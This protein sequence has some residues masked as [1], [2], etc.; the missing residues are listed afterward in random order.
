MNWDT[1]T[2]KDVSLPFKRK[3]YTRRVLTLHGNEMWPVKKENKLTLR[4]A[5]MRMIKWMCGINNRS[6]VAS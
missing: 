2:N 3:L 5:E 1:L 6:R 4:R